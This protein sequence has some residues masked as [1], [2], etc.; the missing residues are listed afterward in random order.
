MKVYV[1]YIN[2]GN[3]SGNEVDSLWSDLETARCYA[4]SKQ[5]EQEESADVWA[6]DDI[7]EVNQ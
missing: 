3:G 6:S 1:V 2:H 7:Y 5:A 4:D